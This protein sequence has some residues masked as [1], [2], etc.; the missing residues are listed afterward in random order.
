MIKML[1]VRRQEREFFIKMNKS[2]AGEKSWCEGHQLADPSTHIL[3]WS[4][5]IVKL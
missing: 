3:F 5:K 2:L 1:W 4:F